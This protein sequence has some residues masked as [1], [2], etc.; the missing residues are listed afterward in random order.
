MNLPDRT[1]DHPPLR[2]EWFAGACALLTTGLCLTVLTGWA[3]GG[4][5]LASFGRGLLPMA[6]STALL[7][8]L[9]A[10]VLLIGPRSRRASAVLALLVAAAGLVLLAQWAIQVADVEDWLIPARPFSASI[11]MGRMSPLTA[12]SL[13]VL[14]VAL[15]LAFS[16]PHRSRHVRDGAA[17]CATAIGLL[18]LVAVEGY[19]SRSPFLYGGSI[20]PIALPTALVLMLLA[21]GVVAAAGPSAWPTREFVGP[22]V[23]ARL[24]RILMPLFPAMV[25]AEGLVER[26]AEGV[27]FLSPALQ[28]ACVMLAFAALGMGV[29]RRVSRHMDQVV[30]DAQD[31]LEE[32]ERRYRRIFEQALTG[33]FLSTAG[34]R[35]LACNQAFARILGFDSVEDALAADTRSF[36]HDAR[37]RERYLEAVRSRGSLEYE[38]ELRRKDGSTVP[39][40]NSVIGIAGP[41]GELAEI[42]GALL[43][44]T[45]RKDLEERLRQAQKM[46]AVEFNNLLA[47]ILGHGERLL[48]DIGSQQ[49][50]LRRVQ[51]MLKA[52]E[53]A[54]TLT[55]QLLAFG[56]K[57]L[58][59]P[60]VLGLGTLVGEM[61]DILKCLI[62][63]NV[64]LVTVLDPQLGSVKADRGQMEEVVMNLAANARDAMPGGGRLTIEA[65]NV[66]IGG[67]GAGHRAGRPGPRVLLAVSDTGTGMDEATQARIFEPFFTTREQGKGTGLGLS[68]VHGIVS[69]SGGHVEVESAP[70]RGTVVRVYLPRVS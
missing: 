15:F 26:A 48:S 31:E 30:A 64:E 68:T 25:L 65:R 50:A 46:E 58:S 7:S 38:I 62:G 36:Y 23:R 33:N 9:L 45:G 19:L 61:E 6:P 20:T 8:L 18:G 53:R 37:D 43:D 4:M 14:G 35:L 42:Q 27:T 54:A 44:M 63:G 57:Q 28:H 5:V 49:P 70:G 51:A 55:R 67:D 56:R 41:D 40:I 66:E 1:T 16:G 21:A 39:V 47:V 34:G 69:Q 2:W 52:A 24:L 32:S 13:G 10:A 59:Q 11:V 22:S 12:A 17:A 29:A 60:T 3:T